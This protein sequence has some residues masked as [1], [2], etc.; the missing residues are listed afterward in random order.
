[1]FAVI[2]QCDGKHFQKQQHHMKYRLLIA[3][4]LCAGLSA[5]SVAQSYPQWLISL[6]PKTETYYYRVA[7][8]TAQTEEAALKKAFAAAIYESA[9]AIGIAVDLSRIEKMA[10]D[11]SEIAVARFVN[12][13]VNK[14]CQ[15]TE[16]LTTRRGYR[17]YVLCQVAGDVR[18]KPKY[19]T[20]NCFFNKEE[21][22]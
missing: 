2:R 9:F 6:P 14:V 12:I 8:A 3:C 4:L 10:A 5:T 16:A 7:Q 22:K 21:E 18:I 20:Y 15:H 17:A 1:M 19:K 13:P 11:S